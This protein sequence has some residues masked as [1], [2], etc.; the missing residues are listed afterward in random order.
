MQ[1]SGE[2]RTPRVRLAELLLALSR[3]VRERGVALACPGWRLE[4]EALGTARWYSSVP[5]AIGE[6]LRR[7]GASGAV[8]YE[9]VVEGLHVYAVYCRP[10]EGPLA[11]IRLAFSEGKKG[12]L[13]VLASAA[14]L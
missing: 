14:R 1:Q 11:L 2:L 12:A 9:G 3:R 10:R 8:V 5:A 13:L 6:A 7:I 4:V